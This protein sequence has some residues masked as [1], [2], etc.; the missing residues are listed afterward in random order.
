MNGRHMPRPR[1]VI[2]LEAVYRRAMLRFFHRAL[3]L[4]LVTEYPKSGA[5]WL[6]QMLSEI[7]GYPFPR[8][9]FPAFGRAIYHGHYL[10]VGGSGPT[11][12]VWRDPRDIMVSWYYHTQ[13]PS[14]RNHPAFVGQYRAAL[15]FA[16]VDDIRSN[17]PRFIDFNFRTPLSPR[18]SFNDFFAAWH[19]RHDVA[20]SRYEDLHATPAAEL[21]RVAGELGFE[22]PAD[23]VAAIVE[24]YSFSKQARRAPGTENTSS[25]LR[26]GIVGDW[27]NHFSTEARQVLADHLGDRLIRLGY[28]DN[29]EWIAAPAVVRG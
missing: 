5:S 25:Y 3:P 15:G 20:H 17:L 13:F 16:D 24:R 26:K 4:V 14:D 23:R 21:A 6:A 10:D 8:Q 2:R 18:F 9:R 11:V 22:A 1:S 12:V 28:E 7:S 19:G 27:R 29:D